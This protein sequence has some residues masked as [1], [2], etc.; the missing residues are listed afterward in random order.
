[1]TTEQSYYWLDALKETLYYGFHEFGNEGFKYGQFKEF[2]TEDK[3]A[4][5]ILEDLR[6]LDPKSDKAQLLLPDEKKIIDDCCKHCE[7]MMIKYG[8]GFQDEIPGGEDYKMLWEGFQQLNKMFAEDA[9]ERDTCFDCASRQIEYEFEDGVLK[10]MKAVDPI[11]KMR[12]RLWDPKF[13]QYFAQAR[14]SRLAIEREEAKKKEVEES[15]LFEQEVFRDCETSSASFYILLMDKADVFKDTEDENEDGD[16]DENKDDDDDVESFV[17]D[18]K[19]T[20][21]KI[22]TNNADIE[23]EVAAGL[24]DKFASLC[25]GGEGSRTNGN[26]HG[27]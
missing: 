25:C 8:G 26:V 7:A 19:E 17:D 5:E 21:C 10:K 12:P 23:N 24:S 1:M 27:T 6:D 3:S 11:L 2:V 4:M 9:M 13:N 15:E 18:K 16:E 14:E 20:Q 22:E